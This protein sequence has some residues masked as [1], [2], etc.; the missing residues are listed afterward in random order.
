MRLWPVSLGCGGVLACVRATV[1]VD[2]SGRTRRRRRG[3]QEIGDLCARIVTGGCGSI[4]RRGHRR[5]RDRRGARSGETRRARESWAGWAVERSR[6]QRRT[7][8]QGRGKALARPLAGNSDRG[9]RD[10]RTSGRRWVVLGIRRQIVTV[11]WCQAVGSG[12]RDPLQGRDSADPGRVAHRA[13]RDVS[14]P[15]APWASALSS[16]VV[17]SIDFPRRAPFRRIQARGIGT[18]Q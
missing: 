10:D 11:W 1:T 15:Y 2:G 18:N 9:A 17:G 5:D 16:A 6:S 14:R 8:R 13:R 3:A 12:S 7:S 4:D